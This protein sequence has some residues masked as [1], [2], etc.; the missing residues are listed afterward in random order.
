MPVPLFTELSLH[1][2]SGW[3]LCLGVLG[4]QAETFFSPH[5]QLSQGFGLS[6]RR[7]PLGEIKGS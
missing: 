5:L 2:L 1:S 6:G 4:V 3:K 7:P